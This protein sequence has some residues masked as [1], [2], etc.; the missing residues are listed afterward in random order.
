MGKQLY[1]RLGNKALLPIL[2][3]AWT[4]VHTQVKPTQRVSE[5]A[6]ENA[7]GATAPTTPVSG[8]ME[9]GMEREFSS[10]EKE[11]STTECLMMTLDTVQER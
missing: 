8:K 2:G 10:Q 5:K 4:L 3:L 7:F 6:L 11:Q 1:K 9:L